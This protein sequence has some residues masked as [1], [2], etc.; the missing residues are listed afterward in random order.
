MVIKNRKFL[1]V[2]GIFLLLNA[3]K[4]EGTEIDT[5]TITSFQTADIA[6]MADSI[7]LSVTAAGNYPLSSIKVTFSRD[8]QRISENIIPIKEAGT[9]NDKLLVPFVKDLEDGPAQIQL[10]VK[11]RNFDYSIQTIPIQVSRPKFPYLTLKTAY[12]DY[13]MEPVAGEPYKYAVT[14]AFPSTILNALIEAPAFGDNG[15]AFYFGGKTIAAYASDQDSIPFQ[16]IIAEGSPF[17]VSFDTRTFEAEP[18]LK[19]S[20]GGIEFPAYSNNTA[21]IE[22]AFSQN[23]TI[24]L[25]GILDINSWWIDPTFLEDNGDGT[26]K[27]RA[28]DGQYR[29]TADQNLKYFKIEPM[30]GDGLADFNPATH[31]GGVYINGGSGNLVG[32]APVERLGIPSLTSNPTLWDAEK[33]IAMAPLGDGIYQIRLIAGTTL[34]QS[35]V[36][37]SNVG[38]SFY[39]NSR[40]IDNPFPIT[41]TQT[42]YG[43][44]GSPSSSAGSP[45]FELNPGN[46]SMVVSGSNRS[47]GNGRTYIFTLDTKT[48][49]AS[50]SISLE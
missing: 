48:S 10:M 36:S 24:A 2:I 12:G 29:I 11:N 5:P 21:V 41:L 47:L 34:F 22:H 15:N 38:I 23:Q 31:S 14:Q 42:L 33:N 4:K 27:F 43:S 35:N 46:S 30:E 18:F 25:D 49:P 26:Y 40:T 1:P 44:P 8:G 7:P 17:T 37:G 28:I 39:Q 9:Y 6:Y 16:K 50:L 19:P 20:F 45:R 3:C 13:K 32:S